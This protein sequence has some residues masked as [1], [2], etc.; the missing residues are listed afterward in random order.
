MKDAQRA[1]IAARL[2]LPNRSDD[3]GTCPPVLEPL[4]GDA[5]PQAEKQILLAHLLR[6]SVRLLV[7]AFPHAKSE[8]EC[9]SEQLHQVEVSPGRM[10]FCAF[11]DVA[12]L[13]SFDAKARPVPLSSRSLLAIVAGR[14]GRLVLNPGPGQI[15]LPKPAVVAALSEDTW[16]APWNDVELIELL[17]RQ[18]QSLSLGGI[19]LLP[20][21]DGS[22]KLVVETTPSEISRTQVTRFAKWLSENPIVLSRCDSLQ[23]IPV[24]V[25]V[26]TPASY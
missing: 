15:V 2:S 19:S 6:S 17:G 12:H 3:Q 18:A 22:Q 9:D 8:T 21:P 24:N 5:L 20:Q 13:E 25:S 4:F 1:K 26:S 14:Q 7:P 11:S 23:L 16:L 10:A